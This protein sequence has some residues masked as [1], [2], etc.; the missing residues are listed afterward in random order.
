LPTATPSG[1]EVPT[2]EEDPLGF[3][4]WRVLG[5]ESE[6]DDGEKATPTGDVQGELQM[7]RD[8]SKTVFNETLAEWQNRVDSRFPGEYYA[9]PGLRASTS[10]AEVKH[11]DDAAVARAHG[12]VPGSRATA[13]NHPEDQIRYTTA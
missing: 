2:I 3:W 10:E 1:I 6:S 9:E 8:D 11:D 13:S 7:V 4:V 12:P 5:I